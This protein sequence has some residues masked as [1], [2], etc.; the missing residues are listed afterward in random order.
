VYEAIVA[1]GPT[2][3][4]PSAIPG[5]LSIE[6]IMLSFRVFGTSHSM[7]W[8]VKSRLCGTIDI[9]ASSRAS[10][11]FHLIS[12]RRSKNPPGSRRGDP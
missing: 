10:G 11:L 9:T 6:R 3:P 4:A 8:S 2:I 7:S 12:E 5:T 1:F